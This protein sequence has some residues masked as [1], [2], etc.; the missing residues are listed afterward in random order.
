MLGSRA[1]RLTDQNNQRASAKPKPPGVPRPPLSFAT[2]EQRLRNWFRLT[3]KL[4]MILD[5]FHYKTCVM[6]AIGE[7][8]YK[9]IFGHL[10]EE[11]RKTNLEHEQ[12]GIMKVLDG[13]IMGEVLPDSKTLKTTE[14]GRTSKLLCQHPTT[15]IK[16]GGNKHERWFTC[17]DC[18]TRWKRTPIPDQS[19]PPSGQDLLLFGRYASEIYHQVYLNHP[20]YALWVLQTAQE[21]PQASPQLLRF[22]Q[23]IQLA[24]EAAAPTASSS[25][26]INEEGFQDIGQS[27]ENTT[28]MD[29]PFM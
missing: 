15:S 29:D 17:L 25:T 23:Y 3:R 6:H 21:S 12:L 9:V 26:Q 5:A 22:A 4:Q 10:R 7:R 27:W 28:D 19:G 20:Q 2:A 16:Q 14:L 18:T 24:K 13:Q 8:P 1:A 11:Q